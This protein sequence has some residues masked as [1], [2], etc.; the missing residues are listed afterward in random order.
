MAETFKLPKQPPNPPNLRI[1]PFG[2]IDLS[3]SQSQIDSNKS[4]DMLNFSIDERGTLNKR[5]G[6]GRLFQTSLGTGPINGLFEFHKANGTTE[7]LVA[8]G[9]NLYR[10]DDLNDL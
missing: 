5:T 1:G 2:G 3:I 8:H 7:M 9:G 10:L 6:Y 4:P